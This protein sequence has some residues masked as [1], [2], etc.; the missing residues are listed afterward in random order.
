[1]FTVIEDLLVISFSIYYFCRGYTMVHFICCFSPYLFP[2]LYTYNI[3]W[4]DT[5]KYFSIYSIYKKENHWASTTIPYP[6][7]S[8]H[9]PFMNF[10]LENT[11]SCIH[12]LTVWNTSR[13]KSLKLNFSTAMTQRVP[14]YSQWHDN[15]LLYFKST[16]SKYIILTI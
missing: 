1:M 9:T 5:V 15:S 12:E 3:Y 8:Q 10:G 16:S 2:F 14:E 4:K 7:A 13:Q 6:Q 11:I